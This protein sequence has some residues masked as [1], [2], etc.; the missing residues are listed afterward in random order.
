[1]KEIDFETLEIPVN[2]TKFLSQVHPVHI[3][4]FLQFLLF[5]VFPKVLILELAPS[6]Q[7][8]QFWFW[9]SFNF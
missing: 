1:M 9:S 2:Y 8:L 7:F 6:I 4:E 3:L 5:G